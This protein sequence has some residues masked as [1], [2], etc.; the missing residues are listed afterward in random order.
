MSNQSTRETPV[1]E[2]IFVPLVFSFLIYIVASISLYP[3]ANYFMGES[4]KINSSILWNV[5]FANVVVAI[6][7]LLF[8]PVKMKWKVVALLAFFSIHFYLGT[9]KQ[10]VINYYLSYGSYMNPEI[11]PENSNQRKIITDIMAHKDMDYMG[12]YDTTYFVKA[13]IDKLGN[14]T[15][16]FMMYGNRNEQMKAYEVKF[17]E[18]LNTPYL[19]AWD[20]K[21]FENEVVDYLKNSEKSLK[22]SESVVMINTIKIGV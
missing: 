16:F 2:A 1:I 20:Y 10:S 3:L 13:D 6:V 5:V 4:F 19:T 21:N 9:Y 8:V 18:L 12:D 11:Y 22:G 15:T 7:I 14:M 17:K